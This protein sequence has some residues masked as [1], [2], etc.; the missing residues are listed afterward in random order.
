MNVSK[1]GKAAV[2]IGGSVPSGSFS[3]ATV[4]HFDEK[5]VGKIKCAIQHGNEIYTGS[6]SDGIK[7]WSIATG[8]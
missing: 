2:P 4:F 7:R 6:Q 8:G 3:W 5:E 1:A